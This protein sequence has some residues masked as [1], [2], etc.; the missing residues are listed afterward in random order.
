MYSIFLLKV[1]FQN[2]ASSV[3]RVFRSFF[4]FTQGKAIHRLKRREKLWG[5]LSCL[6]Q[7]E[8]L[9][10]KLF[11]KYIHCLLA[12]VQQEQLKLDLR[13]G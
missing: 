12:E 11:L 8:P 5:R 3:V 9:S 10:L 6:Q 13:E 1:L 7:T 4:V 2:N